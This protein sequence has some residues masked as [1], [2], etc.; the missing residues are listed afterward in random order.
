M[1]D[2]SS[3][4]EDYMI[5]VD[6][7]SKIE[8]LGSGKNKMRIK[9]PLILRELRCQDVYANIPG[10]L[11]CVPDERVKVACNDLGIEL[12]NISSL[13]G[14]FKASKVIYDNFGDLYDIPL[15]AYEDLKNNDF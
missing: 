3:E 8:G 13:K 7:I 15:F 10:E 4:K 12:P 6:Y 5:F 11:C 9:I 1:L 14:L 2:L